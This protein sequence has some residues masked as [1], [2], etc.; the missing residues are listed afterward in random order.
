VSG[1]DEEGSAAPIRSGAPGRWEQMRRRLR[2]QP[3]TFG[4]A[5]LG[6]LLGVLLRAVV[7]GGPLGSPDLDEATVGVQAFE[8]R[9][10]RFSVFFFNQPYGGTLETFLVTAS[11][12]LFGSSVVALK[13][14][15]IAC[16]A[17]TSFLAWR[18]AVHL[19]LST[20]GRAVT[21]VVSWCWPAYLVVFSTKERAFY[22]VTSVLTMA[23][24][25]LV[26]RL[27]EQ[28]TRR[29]MVLLGLCIG[30]GWW[31][32]PL[33]IGVAVPAVLWLVLRRPPVLRSSG[34]AIGAAIVGALP[35]LIW[36]YRNGWTS[37]DSGTDP[38]TT[39]FSRVQDFWYRLS[40][41]TG[42]QTPFEP[43]RALIDW[44][45]G[46]AVA[47]A[48]VIGAATWRTRRRAPGLLAIS[49]VGYSVIYGLNPAAVIV[50][51]DPRYL[52]FV[53]PL[54]AVCLGALAPEIDTDRHRAAAL[55]SCTLAAGA[56]TV[57][58]VTGMTA[59][60]R[61]PD[62][63]R[64]LASVGIED[65]AALLEERGV[66]AAFSDLGGYQVSFL[67]EGQVVTGSF[68]VP[69]LRSYEMTARLEP[70]STYVLD[71]TVLGNDVRLRTWLNEALID[72]QE[73]T[74]GKWAVFFIE[75]R[76]V[77]EDVPLL[78]FFGVAGPPR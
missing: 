72:Y 32:T 6:V 22:G 57:W 3:W 1:D 58:G 17:A 33:A 35:W 46:A 47:V 64:F 75:E 61:E 49:I 78:T 54:L 37:L 44:P 19:G 59:L 70:A 62:A 23:G 76:V 71:R 4:V 40:T 8:F 2:A 60:A 9:S 14:V 53:V 24:F 39:W 34:W 48:V 42:T 43:D 30:L 18:A 55:A 27:D 21:L 51:P 26:L 67:T 52:F 20:L 28:I 12:W 38:A 41:V 5:A 16:A 7:L 66:E 10:G 50:G 25:V 11:F 36:N 69:R 31:Q 73:E 65:V 13:L 63:N 45:W 56:M 29:D 15:P 68:A 77:P 74:V